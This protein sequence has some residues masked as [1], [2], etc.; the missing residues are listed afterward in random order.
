MCGKRQTL[1]TLLMSRRTGIEMEFRYDTM[2]MGLVK[3]KATATV[4]K[5]EFQNSKEV[6]NGNIIYRML[7]IFALVLA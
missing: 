3:D 4:S 6:Q 7:R 1:F 2:Y 5:E